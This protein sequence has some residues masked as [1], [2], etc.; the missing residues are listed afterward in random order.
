MIVT[1]DKPFLTVG[2]KS[3]AERCIFDLN[4]LLPNTNLN[5]LL[6][7]ANFKH[8]M[9][10]NRYLPCVF[11][12]KRVI[13]KILRLSCSR[14]YFNIFTLMVFI[15]YFFKYEIHEPGLAFY[16]GRQAW[17]AFWRPQP[18]YFFGRWSLVLLF[19]L[20]DNWVVSSVT[21][22]VMTSETVFGC[23]RQNA[24]LRPVKMCVCW[25]MYCLG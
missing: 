7:H 3:R 24:L 18:K 23:G 4:Y 21:V 8:E 2:W 15:W 11:G 25:C 12:Q 19:R 17:S 16:T 10:I 5:Y 20:N 9:V 1:K 6:P 13:A 14:C 22:L